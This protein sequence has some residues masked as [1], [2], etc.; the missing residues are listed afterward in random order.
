MKSVKGDVTVAIPASDIAGKGV[1]ALER[2]E[3]VGEQHSNES[4]HRMQRLL[5]ISRYLQERASRTFKRWSDE[6]FKAW[7][8]EQLPHAML[9]DARSYQ[10]EH[11]WFPPSDDT[12]MRMVK[13]KEVET[14]WTDRVEHGIGFGG[15]LEYRIRSDE[16]LLDARFLM[17]R[18]HGQIDHADEP[19]GLRFLASLRDVCKAAKVCPGSVI[20]VPVQVLQVIEH[21]AGEPE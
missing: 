20:N 5:K 19:F 15:D 10:R 1:I 11:F 9:K 21:Y 6:R 8:E 16:H 4:L 14:Y 13:K 12:A 3:L 17:F 7:K 2:L 18:I